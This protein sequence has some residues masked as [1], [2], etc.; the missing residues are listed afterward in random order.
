MVVPDLPTASRDLEAGL[1]LR[2]TVSSADPRHH[3]RIHLDRS[4]IE[5]T[6]GDRTLVWR[7]AGFF[8][9][10]DDPVDLRR[11][12]HAVR[13]PFRST[14]YTGV[15]GR[16]D[17]VEIDAG[18]VPVPILVRR[19]HPPEIAADWP[20]ALEVP[21]PNGATTLDAVHVTVDE[22]VPA[23]DVYQRLLG[24]PP[25]GGADPSG[26][27]A[28]E[29]PLVSGRVVLIPGCDVGTG[30]I[31]LGVAETRTTNRGSIRWVDPETTHG[32]KLGLQSVE[33]VPRGPHPF[34]P[35]RSS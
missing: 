16:W 34:R 23:V 9:S 13:L 12:L 35:R 14:V 10:F 5:V 4:Y 21:H 18:G 26:T 2:V 30:A 3:G 29:F 31:V 27:A 6:S 32:L 15:D 25:A 20:P 28:V 19:T 22:L 33:A 8:L 24:V 17:D 7:I 11:H 1:G